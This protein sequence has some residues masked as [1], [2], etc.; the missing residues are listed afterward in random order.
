M[1]S[2]CDQLSMKMITDVTT[3]IRNLNLRADSMHPFLF[4]LMTAAYPA[5]ETLYF[6]KRCWKTENALHCR[7]HS[8]VKRQRY[9]LRANSDVTGSKEAVQWTGAR[10]EVPL[11]IYSLKFANTLIFGRHQS[12]YRHALL[13]VLLNSVLHACLLLDICVL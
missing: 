10:I 3:K 5:S 1:E 2:K 6:N 12:L 4:H 11:F 7:M 8:V 13:A 9:E